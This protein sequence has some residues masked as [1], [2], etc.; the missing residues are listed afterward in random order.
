MRCDDLLLG[1]GLQ[2]ARL[3]SEILGE[4]PLLLPG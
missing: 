2:F 1:W 4:A 3:E